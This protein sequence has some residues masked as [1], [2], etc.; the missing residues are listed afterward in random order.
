V[1]VKMKPFVES[2]VTKE[3]IGKKR[4]GKDYRQDSIH[5]LKEFNQIIIKIVLYTTMNTL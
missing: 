3:T 5:T 2:Y 4:H 1:Q